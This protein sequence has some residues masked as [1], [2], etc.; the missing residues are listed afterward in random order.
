MIALGIVTGLITAGVLVGIGGG[1]HYIFKQLILPA[2]VALN[3]I[4]LGLGLGLAWLWI[5]MIFL[6]AH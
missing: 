4:L 3:L 2:A 6:S 5:D 1:I